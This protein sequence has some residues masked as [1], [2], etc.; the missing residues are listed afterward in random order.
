MERPLKPGTASIQRTAP[1]TFTMDTTTP[2]AT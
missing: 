2:Y 1:E